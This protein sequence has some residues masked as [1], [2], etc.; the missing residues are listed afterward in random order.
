MKKQKGDIFV[1]LAIV[2][3]VLAT[4]YSYVDTRHKMEGSPSYDRNHDSHMYES[5]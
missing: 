1:I 3:G 5:E 4:T 2:L